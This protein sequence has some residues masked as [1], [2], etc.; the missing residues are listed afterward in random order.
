MATTLFSFHTW[1]VEV[2][3]PSDDQQRITA[4]I[5][6]RGMCVPP[7]PYAPTHTA[8]YPPAPGLHPGDTFNQRATW[9]A[10]LAA[11]SQRRTGRWLTL[12]E[13][14]LPAVISSCFIATILPLM[15]RTSH[16]QAQFLLLSCPE[17][18][19]LYSFT[20]CAHS[21]KIEAVE[22]VEAWKRDRQRRGSK[23]WRWSTVR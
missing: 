5:V 9:E 16:K 19:L 14:G 11:S 20:F 22:A 3:S 4:G 21:S 23:I 13:P 7:E 12:S 8:P 1:R 18:V 15:P 17:G 6:C 2:K 10:A